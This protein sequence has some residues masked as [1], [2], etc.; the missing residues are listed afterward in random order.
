MTDQ[1][2]W[3]TPEQVAVMFAVSKR[4]P[5]RWAREGLVAHV[6]TPGGRVKFRR[7]VIVAL[8]SPGEV[9]GEKS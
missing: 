7:A 1:E 4:T 5:T 3:L 2:E 6:R 9:N 8:L